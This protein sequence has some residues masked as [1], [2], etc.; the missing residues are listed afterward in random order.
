MNDDILL[1]EEVFFQNYSDKIKLYRAL[2]EKLMEVFPDS[3]IRVQKTQISFDFPVNGKDR[4]FC[5]FWLP[6]RAADRQKYLGMSFGLTEPLESPR[7]MAV[8]EAQPNRFT[9]HLMLQSPDEL[10][11]ELLGWLK[12]G[13]AWRF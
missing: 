13:R 2:K 9:H 6:R 12:R 10:D 1:E 11:E 7:L 4:L 8:V 5:M 3:K